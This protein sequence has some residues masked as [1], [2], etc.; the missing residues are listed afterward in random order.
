M[1][2]NEVTIVAKPRVDSR[3]MAPQFY[4]FIYFNTIYLSWY[5]QVTT[6]KLILGYPKKIKIKF[7]LIK[8]LVLGY[9]MTISK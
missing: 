4:L 6:R 9:L 2:A 7:T 8:L 1:V 5:S 3:S